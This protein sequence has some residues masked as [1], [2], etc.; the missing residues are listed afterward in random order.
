MQQFAFDVLRGIS[1]FELFFLR[2]WG[3]VAASL[4]SWR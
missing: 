4:N 2:D 1:A 3:V